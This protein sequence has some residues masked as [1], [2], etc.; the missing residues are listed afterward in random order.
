MALGKYE[1][2]RKGRIFPDVWILWI[3]VVLW[4]G[5]GGAAAYLSVSAGSVSNQFTAAEHPTVTVNGDNS[6]TVDAHG[7]AVYLRAAVVVNWKNDDHV[8]A[9]MP[10]KNTDYVLT[11]GNDWK[12]INGFYY[13][14]PVISSTATTTPVVTLKELSKKGGYELEVTVAA[15]VVQAVGQTDDDPKS[16]VEDAWSISEEQIT[17]P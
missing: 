12:E 11:L 16:A 1:T 10:I 14:Q 7:Y 5:I 6:I 3:L 2:H 4:I 15:Q 17:A 8:L 13:Y 9:Q